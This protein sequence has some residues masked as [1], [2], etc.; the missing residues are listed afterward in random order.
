MRQYYFRL[1]DAAI[2]INIHFIFNNVDFCLFDIFNQCSYYLIGRFAMEGKVIY[3]SNK[4][5]TNLFGRR[6][7]SNCVSVAYDGSHPCVEVLFNDDIVTIAQCGS[8]EIAVRLAKELT[9]R[10]YIDGMVA[11]QIM[12]TFS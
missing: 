3:M 2:I 12:E 9:I 8:P 6:K 10:P 11:H 1:R 4:F 5:A 7:V